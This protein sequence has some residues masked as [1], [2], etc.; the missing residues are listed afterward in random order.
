QRIR[1]AV[2]LLG[3]RVRRTKHAVGAPDE[4]RERLG[5]G[6]SLHGVSNLRG[7]RVAASMN[8]GFGQRSLTDGSYGQY[9]S[10]V[11]APLAETVGAVPVLAATRARAVAF[12]VLA[13]PV[14]CARAR[15]VRTR[16][17][18]HVHAFTPTRT[19]EFEQLVR[20]VG[21][22]AVRK[23]DGWRTDWPAY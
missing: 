7:I 20:L 23:V 17:R 19:G 12:E 22:T 13:A 18:G 3:Q 21:M 5:G 6:F 16:G 8:S 14:P 1:R 9:K 4:P 2:C 15:V 11:A 10:G